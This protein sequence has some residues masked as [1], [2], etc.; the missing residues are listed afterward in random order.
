MGFTCGGF[1]SLKESI[2]I[3]IKRLGSFFLDIFKKETKNKE[4][5]QNN[6]VHTHTQKSLTLFKFASLPNRQ[7]FFLKNASV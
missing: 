7:C 3:M 5:R 2:Y 1:L 6:N 4:D